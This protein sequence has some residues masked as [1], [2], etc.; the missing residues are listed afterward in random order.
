ME[1]NT[2]LG[3]LYCKGFKA[4]LLAYCANRD[5]LLYMRLLA[6]PTA[7][8]AI[9]AVLNSAKARRGSRL[10]TVMDGSVS[11]EKREQWLAK[12]VKD[13]A[14]VVMANPALIETGLDLVAFATLVYLGIPTYSIYTVE[15]S[16]RR[17]WRLGQTEPVHVHF[18]VYGAG[19]CSRRRSTCSATRR[20]RPTWCTGTSRAGWRR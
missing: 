8:K 14:Q 12:A 2:M 9:W 17:S 19:R 3:E 7:D 4:V 13:G 6:P 1:A 18:F 15:Q 16:K 20:G 11:P 5:G 10:D